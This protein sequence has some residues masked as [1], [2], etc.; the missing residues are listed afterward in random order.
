MTLT[1]LWRGSVQRWE[2]DENDHLNVRFHF[3]IADEALAYLCARHGQRPAPRVLRQHARFIAEARIATPLCARGAIVAADAAGLTVYI[4]IANGLNGAPHSCF[5]I[6]VACEADRLDLDAAALPG[7]DAIPAHGARRG[8]IDPMR[9][10]ELPTLADAEAL[11]MI[12]IARGVIQDHETRAGALTSTACAGRISDGVLL[13]IAH[14]HGGRTLAERQ[15]GRIGGAVVEYE[16]L[17]PNA[18]PAGTAFVGRS[19]IGALQ[20]R[21][22]RFAHWLFCAG[23]GTLLCAANAIAVPLDLETR[24]AATYDDEVRAAI[25]ARCVPGLLL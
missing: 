23:S 24:R 21:T 14:V 20:G 17:L 4:E 2:C 7:I 12:E 18:T 9:T 1:P 22:Q 25:E 10:T 15:S 6:T 19:G 3:A 5:T 16:L 13:L 11:P 8:L